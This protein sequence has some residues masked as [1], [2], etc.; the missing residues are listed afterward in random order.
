MTEVVFECYGAPSLAYGIDSLFSYNYNQGKTGL[1]VSSSYSSTHVIPV[2]NSK[3][4]LAQ[5]I[6]LNWGGSHAAEYLL[7]LVKLK[8]RDFLGNNVRLHPSQAEFWLKDFCYLS[9]DYDEEIRT[10]LDWT[11][12]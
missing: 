8:Y 6:R 9:K 4:M 7:K 11:G 2:Y 1:V 5:A 3:A 10:Y 12:L